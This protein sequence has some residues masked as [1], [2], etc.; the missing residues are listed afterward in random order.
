MLPILPNKFVNETLDIDGEDAGEKI[1]KLI[2]HV[3]EGELSADEARKIASIIQ[4]DAE[5]TNQA[6]LI[7]KLTFL[8]EKLK[9]DK[10]RDISFSESGN[11]N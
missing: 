5:I 7:K 6:T 4:K 1:S 11:S 2:N 3:A 9:F 8:E 10:T